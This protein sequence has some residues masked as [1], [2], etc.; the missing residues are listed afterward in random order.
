MKK[1]HKL[2]I[3]GAIVLS[4][5]IASCASDPK[6]QDQS[7][8]IPG[9]TEDFSDLIKARN[10]EA[11]Y[12]SAVASSNFY[13]DTTFFGHENHS[14]EGFNVTPNGGVYISQASLLNT[15]KE[16]ISL[17]LYYSAARDNSKS[18]HLWRTS[19]SQS[20][21]APVPYDFNKSKTGL[22]STAADACGGGW[23]QIRADAL[24]GQYANRDASFN[25]QRKVCE[26]LESNGQP[27]IYFAIR[28]ETGYPYP[29]THIFTY[30]DGRQLLFEDTAQYNPYSKITKSTPGATLNALNVENRAVWQVNDKARVF[31]FDYYGN[32]QLMRL[33]DSTNDYVDLEYK[34]AAADANALAL[35]GV[36]PTKVITLT[37]HKK[38]SDAT[39]DS[40]SEK[41]ELY[42][43]Q[44]NKIVKA[45]SLEPVKFI[46]HAV[47]YNDYS[48][49]EIQ[50]YVN[51][52]SFHYNQNGLVDYISPYDFSNVDASEATSVNDIINPNY[53]TASFAYNQDNK[54]ISNSNLFETIAITYDSNG[55]PKYLQSMADDIKR[56]YIF[57]QRSL[58]Q[59]DLKT[60]YIEKE[61]SY[62]I[63]A[64]Q[65]RIASTSSFDVNVATTSNS[66]TETKLTYSYDA[67][68]AVL[69]S[70]SSNVVE[71]YP[72]ANLLVA[73]TNYIPLQLAADVNPYTQVP[74]IKAQIDKLVAN[75]EQNKPGE[76]YA[77]YEFDCQGYEQSLTVGYLDKLSFGDATLNNK[78]KEIAGRCPSSDG[79][80]LMIAKSSISNFDATL[81]ISGK[82]EGIE[83]YKETKRECKWYSIA[84]LFCKDVDHWYERD[85][86]KVVTFPAELI[87][88]EIF[89]R[90]TSQGDILN[91]NFGRKRYRYYYL[92]AGNKKEFINSTNDTTHAAYENEAF[93]D[94][95]SS[96]SPY[97]AEDLRLKSIKAAN[98][99]YPPYGTFLKGTEFK[100]C[101]NYLDR[102]NKFQDCRSNPA[103]TLYS[104]IKLC[105]PNTY[106]YFFEGA[107][108][109]R[110]EDKVVE[111][112]FH[113][114]KEVC[115]G[116][117]IT[118]YAASNNIDYT[119]SVFDNDFFK[120]ELDKRDPTKDIIVFIG[121]S[122]GAHN[123][124]RYSSKRNRGETAPLILITTDPVFHLPNITTIAELDSIKSTV[125]NAI[126]DVWNW[127]TF[128]AH[129]LINI[130]TQLLGINTSIMPMQSPTY[131]GLWYNT[132]ATIDNNSNLDASPIIVENRS[133]RYC[134]SVWGKKRCVEIPLLP[135]I[136]FPGTNGSWNESDWIAW[137]G[138]KY[139]DAPAGHADFHVKAGVHHNGFYH[140]LNCTFDNL[141]NK[142]IVDIEQLS[143][144]A[145]GCDDKKLWEKKTK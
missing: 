91:D 45:V 99:Y 13:L 102:L 59:V 48:E 78:I 21:N 62:A 129:S 66:A 86:E 105:D 75:E 137:V 1:N 37:S 77:K 38:S 23:Q 36:T 111:E 49:G 19:Y 6:K 103:Q 120:N 55:Y 116:K 22:Y 61:Y 32:N 18:T 33:A 57:N 142:K 71:N 130:V 117:N 72:K 139:F 53:S 10:I 132:R 95:T 16:T 83:S 113:D 94:S 29:G 144:E 14:D 90:S 76:E 101:A 4:I 114:L 119:P 2:S 8:N 11:S 84:G 39:G 100:V 115:D 24:G 25:T 80:E 17:G 58:Q 145:F 136:K 65:Q 131:Y 7:S 85:A 60:K 112:Y 81:A 27:I 35:Y 31:N 133:K 30:E 50:Q 69:Q 47:G 138:Q 127:F 42:L 88:K 41:M 87:G 64:Q 51:E 9:K 135:S 93:K 104:P 68:T 126:N 70:V 125:E 15:P 34:N 12:L 44:D 122:W 79:E 140:M 134:I 97:T 96:A 110:S 128:I 108:L 92:G 106:I 89:G 5:F 121:H 107:H 118:G 26:V 141:V 56:M 74:E 20:L 63:V 82:V 52:F 73:V 124:I 123:A 40:I 98:I 109:G 3:F 28:S 67:S 54:L 43:T 46:N 143:F